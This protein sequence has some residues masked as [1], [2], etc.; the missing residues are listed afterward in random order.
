VKK[1]TLFALFYLCLCI[2]V[3]GQPSPKYFFTQKSERFFSDKEIDDLL[4]AAT[5]EVFE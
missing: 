3:F 1:Q 4:Y 2:A 5:K